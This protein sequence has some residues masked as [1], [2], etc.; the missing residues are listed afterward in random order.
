MFGLNEENI[1]KEKIM[2]I[3]DDNIQIAEANKKYFEELM[4]KGVPVNIAV[5]LLRNMYG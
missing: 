4:E 1:T 2:K 3:L 5:E